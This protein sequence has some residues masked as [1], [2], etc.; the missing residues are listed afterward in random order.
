M[1]T[2]CDLEAERSSNRKFLLLQTAGDEADFA[3]ELRELGCE[4][5]EQ[6][7]R[8]LRAVLP[9]SVEVSDLYRI[10]ARLGTQIRRMDYK[11][12]SLEDIFLRAMAD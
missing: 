6:S 9:A 4:V 1:A 3:R 12:D 7:R 8:Q 5:A 2:V 10:A 11:R